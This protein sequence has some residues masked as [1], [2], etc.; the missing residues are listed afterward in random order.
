[1]VGFT[2]KERWFPGSR[3]SGIRRLPVDASL[4]K[5]QVTGW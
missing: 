4:L 3:L 5:R 2:P 1:M